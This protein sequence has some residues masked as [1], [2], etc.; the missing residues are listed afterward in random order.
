LPVVA[1]DKEVVTAVGKASGGTGRPV[2][3]GRQRAPTAAKRKMVEATRTVAAAS[4][5]RR[6]R[7]RG[8]MGQRGSWLDWRRRRREEHGR[9]E[10]RIDPIQFEL[11]KGRGEERT[12]ESQPP[13]QVLLS[14]IVF[15]YF[16]TGPSGSFF[17]PGKSFWNS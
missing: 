15:F 16:F 14:R 3:A 10:W 4:G 7:P 8:A 9:V 6:V 17:F 2:S 12:R 5:R 11:H 13:S 1:L